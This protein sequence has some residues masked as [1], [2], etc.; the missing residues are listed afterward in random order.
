MADARGSKIFKKVGWPCPVD[1]PT[2]MSAP[3]CNINCA[4]WIL[5]TTATKR[6]E[7]G[8]EWRLGG[9]HGA[10]RGGYEQSKL[11][12]CM[13]LKTKYPVFLN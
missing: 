3:L 10:V 13:K 7:V 5:K 2:P 6:P 1:G 11:C 4:Q 8:G 12:P 9:E